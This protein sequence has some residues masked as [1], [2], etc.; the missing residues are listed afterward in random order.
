MSRSGTPSRAARKSKLQPK[1]RMSYDGEFKKH[2][3]KVALQRPRDNRI[4]PTCALFPGIEPCQLRKWIRNYEAS[5]QAASAT[6]KS[7][8]GGNSTSRKPRPTPAATPAAQREPEHRTTPPPALA[9]IVMTT[10]ADNGRA[11]CGRAGSDVPTLATS[12]PTS[13]T[14]YGEAP[15]LS[16]PASTPRKARRVSLTP[17]KMREECPPRRV[18]KPLCVGVQGASCEELTDAAGEAP[19]PP[20]LSSAVPLGF[21]TMHFLPTRATEW[22]DV[23]GVVAEPVEAW[24]DEWLSEVS[25]F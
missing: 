16:D 13:P 25:P 19:L 23:D 3:V 11:G 8:S 15:N 14:L 21:R 18:G 7:N 6:K 1:K 24:V 17:N 20:M 9:P 5:M 4:K 22:P 10:S 12:P 2:V